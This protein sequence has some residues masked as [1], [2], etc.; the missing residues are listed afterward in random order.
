MENSRTTAQYDRTDKYNLLYETEW[1]LSPATDTTG[2][3][4][5]TPAFC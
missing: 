1:I 2:N 5:D 3:G 4:R